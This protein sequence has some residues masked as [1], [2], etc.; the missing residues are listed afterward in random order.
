MTLAASSG[1]TVRIEAPLG[2][3]PAAA[4]TDAVLAATAEFLEAAGD[5]AYT[6][7]CAAFH[8]G[9]IGQHVRHL[10]DHV[11]AALAG[12]GGAE[13]DYDHRRRDTPIETSRSAALREIQSRRAEAR[14]VT[15]HVAD[16]PAAVR[17]MLTAD[18]AEAVLGSTIGRELAFAAHHAIHH[19]AMIS[20]IA[21]ELGMTP[22]PGFGR[23][24]A[25]L[26][27]ERHSHP[28]PMRR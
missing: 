16:R 23:A 28:S 10:L 5:A 25:T 19:H 15:A 3:H 1:S 18:G 13:I 26:H 14:E 20:A 2:M 6:Q 8:S 21:G 17:V 24:P 11:A 4:A 27:H 7:P 12:V 22:P 9:T